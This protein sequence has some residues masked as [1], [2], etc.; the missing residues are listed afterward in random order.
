MIWGEN[1]WT[2][3]DIGLGCMKEG[4]KSIGKVFSSFVIWVYEKFNKWSRYLTENN[5]SEKLK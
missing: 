1:R 3:S 4:L 5:E 2:V